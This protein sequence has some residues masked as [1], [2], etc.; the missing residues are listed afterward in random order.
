MCNWH[1]K[2]EERKKKMED[3]LRNNNR[4]NL[5][6]FK[7]IK[8]LHKSGACDFIYNINIFHHTRLT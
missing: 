5:P 3:M 2:V 4:K 8:S 6:T 7:D 1:P